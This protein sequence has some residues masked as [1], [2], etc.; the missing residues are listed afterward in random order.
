M[1]ANR[2]KQQ[3]LQ[4]SVP[5][6]FGAC[7]G[8]AL[9]MAENAVFIA[10][11]TPCAVRV[12]Q[13]G[14]LRLEL[15]GGTVEEQAVVVRVE[16]TGIAVVSLADPS[17]L[18]TVS[19]SL[20]HQA[21]FVSHPAKQGRS[22]QR[23]GA[24]VRA[25]DEQAAFVRA[26]VEHSLEAIVVTDIHGRVVE[27]NPAAEA[28]FG[29]SRAELLG[30]DV[31]DFVVPPEHLAAH[32]RGLAALL[33]RNDLVTHPVRRRMKSTAR[34]ASG[35]IIAVDIGLTS[36][37]LSGSVHLMAFIQDITT[38]EQLSQA[39][40]DTLTTAEVAHRNKESELLRIRASEESATRSWQT[41]QLV[42]S[43]LRLPIEDR[44]LEQVIHEAV[45]LIV[46]L[47]WLAREI[48]GCTL[49]WRPLGSKG[50]LC[51]DRSDLPESPQ[52]FNCA[53][54]PNSY[55]LCRRDSHDTHFCLPIVLQGEV[56]GLL[57]L[58]LLQEAQHL[59]GFDVAMDNISHS[60]ATLMERGHMYQALKQS[61]D[62][63]EL[64]NRAKSEFL[65]SMSHEIR[66]PLNAIIGMTDLI[67]HSDQSREEQQGNL[68]IVHSASLALLDII[69]SILDLSKIE[70]GHLV[71][72][73]IA[74][75]LLGQVEKSCETA[76]VKAHQKGLQLYCQVDPEL[77]ETLIGDPS[78]LGQILINLASNAV[79]FTEQGEV[80]VR[81][82]PATDAAATDGT[83][84]IHCAVVDTGIGIPAD[85]QALIFEKFTQADGS[86][87]RKYGGT[88]LGL[89][90]SRHLVQ[91]MGGTIWVESGEGRGSTFHFTARFG[92]APVRQGKK[93]PSQAVGDRRGSPTATAATLQGRRLLLAD[94]NATGRLV[95]GQMLTG[96]A[97]DLT[98]VAS[99]DELLAALDQA[100]LQGTPF[101]ALVIDEELVRADWS[102]SLAT[103]P[104]AG[105]CGQAVILLSSH[106]VF[107]DV[108]RPAFLPQALPLKKPVRRFQ[109]LK[110]LNQT[111]GVVAAEE[112][113]PS[114]LLAS[115]RR[116]NR[117]P[118]H[119]LVVDDVD[120][121]QK[122]AV[123]ILH[124]AGHRSMVA[125]GGEEA[126]RLLRDHRFD[127]VLMDLQ[128]PGMDGF[129]AT[130]HIRRGEAG[131]ANRTIPVIA[132]TAA[133]MM[134]ERQRCLDLGINQFLAKPYVPSQLLVVM[135]PWLKPVARAGEGPAVLLK[136]VDVDAATLQASKRHF[137]DEALAQLQALLQ[138]L[139]HQDVG[140][141]VRAGVGLRKM[142][143]AIGAAR[144]ATQTVRLVGHAEMTDWNEAQ[145][146]VPNLENYVNK[147]VHFLTEEAT[148]DEDFDC[149][150]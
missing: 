24:V 97:A 91:S 98:I 16:S 85:K 10:L 111:L 145:A 40:L 55:C 4:L 107:K 78:R 54:L 1:S 127:L 147:V 130:Q 84:L 115:F 125:S 49:F 75:D 106:V 27:F 139:N 126:L 77:P 23:V 53:Q 35:Q 120:G 37:V 118:L 89:T 14:T 38:R 13:Q 92:I 116:N 105:C 82:A 29:Y 61:R 112:P 60:L 62:R 146:M 41:Q 3:R 30:H 26:I 11:Q 71:L 57:E 68:T 122:L 108:V 101:D 80:V 72:E 121:N 59:P 124:H 19:Q 65:A 138:G 45:D 20:C 32:Q 8:H 119:V 28:L 104:H 96:W 21:T 140:A 113:A 133:T 93:E 114:S 18:R 6:A 79:K 51:V 74:F 73:S 46:A 123:S 58:V 135:E 56:C 12:G 63:A 83:L 143:A 31:G 136:P 67:L 33:T 36:A 141:V 150:R 43:L 110:K 90:I 70:A 87:T 44:S 25:L 34:H 81:V 48:T 100:V 149:R 142:A 66:S 76:A 103:E 137:L 144:I 2:R 7:S 148:T 9:D 94:R 102:S 50:P 109:L 22:A 134:D 64:A 42:T 5:L 129:E 39:L 132:L 95:V 88:G 86:T 99:A 17:A 52:S 47:P 131:E 128:M 69:N 117:T 15:H